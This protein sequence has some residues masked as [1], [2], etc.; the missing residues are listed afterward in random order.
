MAR[1]PLAGKP[2]PNELLVNVPRLLSRYYETSPDPSDP[3]TTTPG[4]VTSNGTEYEYLLY[5]PRSYKPG[6]KA[7]LLVTKAMLGGM[8]PGGMLVLSEKIHFEDAAL[9]FEILTDLL[10]LCLLDRQR[11]RILLDA[12]AREHA[13]VDHGAIHSRRHAQ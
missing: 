1:H 9:V 4:T 12:I 5:T 13:H 10:E 3:G 2:A 6:R 8:K 11:T 7:P